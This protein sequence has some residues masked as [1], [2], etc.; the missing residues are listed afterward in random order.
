M[1]GFSDSDRP[2]FCWK[3]AAGL[4]RP[5]GRVGGSAKIIQIAARKLHVKVQ[6]KNDESQVYRHERAKIVNA[7]NKQFTSDNSI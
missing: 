6:R 4:Q 1:R 7:K 3:S 2:Q 5:R